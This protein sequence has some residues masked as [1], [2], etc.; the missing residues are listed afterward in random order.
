M[1][2]VWTKLQGWP[3][4]LLS[5]LALLT[6]AV[7]ALW[8]LRW[9]PPVR[10]PNQTVRSDEGHLQFQGPGIAISKTEPGWLAKV[11]GQ[12][13]LSVRLRVRAYRTEQWGPARIFTISRDTASRNLTL[14]QMGGDLALRFRD[15]VGDRNGLPERT[16]R[17]VFADGQSHDIRCDVFAGALRI[18][19]DDA[20]CYTESISDDPFSNWD[21]RC[22]VALGNEVTGNRPWLGEVSHAYIETAYDRVDYLSANALT[23]PSHYWIANPFRWTHDFEDPRR[24]RT[25]MLDAVLNFSFFV[26]V[27]M[28]LTIAAG[29]RSSWIVPIG[30]AGGM[31]VAVECTQF[32]FA[33]RQPTATD[34]VLN[35]AGAAIG[36]ALARRWSKEAAD[37][38]SPR[39]IL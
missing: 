20:L 29:R 28:V 12:Q 11:R 7:A 17:D 19:V 10:I 33:F 21:A 32:F 39:P 15:A 35:V 16:V 5:T 14:A 1:N 37:H 8:P 26:P 2:S 30:I 38:R 34:T 4:Y 22:R 13:Q 9:S 24:R 23:V 3:G 6:F 18:F 36:S 27:G 25:E 31:S